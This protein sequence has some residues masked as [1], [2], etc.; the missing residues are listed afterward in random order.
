MK[1]SILFLVMILASAFLAAQE[2][3]VPAA[4]PPAPA[5]DQPEAVVTQDTF[6]AGN[7]LKGKKIEHAFL[8]KNA[9]KAE[10]SILSAK[11]G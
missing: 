6:D 5:G 9:G 4:V 7:V 11:A 10:L 8:V 1:R 2:P 3:A